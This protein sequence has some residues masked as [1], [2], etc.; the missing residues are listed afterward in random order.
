M[1]EKAS[2][3]YVNK[4]S[5]ETNQKAQQ[6]YQQTQIQLS[7][8]LNIYQNE[9]NEWGA[10]RSVWIS[11]QNVQGFSNELQTKYQSWQFQLS[12]TPEEQKNQLKAMIL[13]TIDE[14]IAQLK[15]K[16]N[17]FKVNKQN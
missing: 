14:Q 8:Q 11:Q 13:A 9:Q 2:S 6:S 10:V 3:N 16:S 17:E 12:D 1:A 7:Q 15:K 4:Q 5:I